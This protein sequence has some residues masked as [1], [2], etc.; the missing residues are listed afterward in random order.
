MAVNARATEFQSGPH[1]SQAPAPVVD[2]SIVIPCRNGAASI[3]A[4]VESIA[5]QISTADFEI[6]VADNGSTDRSA[7]EVR[8]IPL[9]SAQSIRVIDAGQRRGANF[10]RNR[11]A[12]VAMGSLLV[13]C[14]ADD[15]VGAGW[16]DAFWT[17]FNDGV[18]LAGGTCNRFYPENKGL[19]SARTG[20]IDG[21]NFLPWP[22]G[23]N[24]AVS[25]TVFDNLRGF[26]ET[27]IH[28]GDE[29]EF[30][31]R[32]QLRGYALML[33]EGA[34][35]TYI[36]RPLGRPAFRQSLVYGR[37]HVSLYAKFHSYGMPRTP[38]RLV[39]ASLTRMVFLFA[40]SRPRSQRRSE[41]LKQLGI[42]LGRL[43]QSAK[44][45]IWFP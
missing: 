31:W 42:Q 41:A 12:E 14:D 34:E 28:G 3:R 5:D 15:R 25:R 38:F 29:T 22:T 1:R 21:L 26:D 19:I 20:L 43:Q 7:E 16:L 37:S 27:F 33:V 13:F 10:A 24:C 45:R 18:E 44:L 23:A 8:S 30:F 2:I 4:Q 17:A 9:G 35:I 6:L 11:G 32:A 39:L 40:T 36:Q